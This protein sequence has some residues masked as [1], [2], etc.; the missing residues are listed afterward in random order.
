[1]V[2]RMCTVGPIL[3]GVTKPL[4]AIFIGVQIPQV[5]TYLWMLTLQTAIKLIDEIQT[6]LSIRMGRRDKERGRYL[7]N[8]KSKPKQDRQDHNRENRGR[9]RDRN[10][11]YE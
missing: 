3:I 4:V 9:D 11:K 2:R 6:T 7:I 1:M 8:R 10:K 5:A